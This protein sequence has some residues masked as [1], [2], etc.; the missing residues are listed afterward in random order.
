VP[1]ELAGASGAT[2][3]AKPLHGQV[4]KR[5]AVFQSVLWLDANSIVALRSAH[6]QK[7]AERDRLC[8]RIFAVTSAEHR[9][10]E[11]AAKLVEYGGNY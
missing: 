11:N 8:F 9:D 10:Q 6:F 7:I 2:S 3:A 4:V 1:Q 5:L